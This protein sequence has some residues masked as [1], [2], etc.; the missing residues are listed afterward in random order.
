MNRVGMVYRPWTEVEDAVM[1]E[2]YGTMKAKDIGAEL[3]R[4]ESAVKSRAGKLGIQGPPTPPTHGTAGRYRAGCR[5]VP[6]SKAKA[7]KDKRLRDERAARK[8]SDLPPPTHGYSGY[9]NFGCRCQVCGDAR[10]DYLRKVS[11]RIAGAPIPSTRRDSLAWI[12]AA[13]CRGMDTEI[14]FANPGEAERVRHVKAVCSDCPVVEQ[15][16]ELGLSQSYDNFGIFGGTTPGER[17][18]I[19]R[20]R[21]ENQEVAA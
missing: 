10:R 1:R 11:Y 16:L 17:R 19:R 3:D 4:T 20:E 21:R 15:C 5:C 12:D 2:L 13:A 14:F 6:C 9:T 18:R 7:A 8:A